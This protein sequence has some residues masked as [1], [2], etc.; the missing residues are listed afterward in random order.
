MFA[1][2]SD[3]KVRDPPAPTRRGE[4][5]RERRERQEG[6][7]AACDRGFLR[8]SLSL[9]PACLATAE[10][11]P[12]FVLYS[13]CCVT[14]LGVR[15]CC[16]SSACVHQCV[17]TRTRAARARGGARARAKRRLGLW[18]A[19]ATIYAP[20]CMHHSS[21]TS[22]CSNACSY[23]HKNDATPAVAYRARTARRRSRAAAAAAATTL[24]C[25]A[26]ELCEWMDHAF[27]IGGGPACKGCQSVTRV[28]HAL[29]S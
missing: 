15:F 1:S 9:A 5:C 2:L 16:A 27:W 10:D 20:R 3:S 11:R 21:C 29:R 19:R 6:L 18:R 13:L 24:C 22:S 28:L 8:A 12:C 14:R 26:R 25:Q 23:T 17:Q 4:R 7:S